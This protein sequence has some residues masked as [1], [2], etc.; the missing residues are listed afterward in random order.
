MFHGD[1]DTNVGVGESRLMLSRL[2][3]A[4]GQAELV[5][6]P[7]LDHQLDDSAARTWMLDQADAFLRTS[8]G[9]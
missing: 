1:Q 7:G 6:F 3:A 5:V 4:G 9:L 2:K 8:L